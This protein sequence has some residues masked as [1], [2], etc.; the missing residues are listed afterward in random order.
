MVKRYFTRVF[1]LFIAVVATGCVASGPIAMDGRITNINDLAARMS[2]KYN[3]GLRKVANA[4]SQSKHHRHY[5]NFAMTLFNVRATMGDVPDML[6]S[7]QNYCWYLGGIQKEVGIR[8]HNQKSYSL[9]CEPKQYGRVKD[10]AYFLFF[11]NVLLS[12]K[13]QTNPEVYKTDTRKTD[14]DHANLYIANRYNAHRQGVFRHGANARNVYPSNANGYYK[15]PQ[16]T[17]SEFSNPGHSIGYYTNARNENGYYLKRRNT[18][19]YDPYRRKPAV[20]SSYPRYA[21]PDNTVAKRTR[22]ASSP[23]Y[24][25]NFL[26]SENQTYDTAFSDMPSYKKRRAQFEKVLKSTRAHC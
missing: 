23:A 16:Y 18:N 25:V 10:P 7:F 6:A 22:S 2:N 4:P 19:P 26:I 13:Y 9:I 24:C 15:D 12:P 5:G 17:S 14:I 21:N 20:I 1:V 11:V 8:R 3:I